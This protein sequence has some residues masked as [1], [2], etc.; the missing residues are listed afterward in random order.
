MQ[1]QC[2]SEIVE[3]E[4]LYVD[5]LSLRTNRHAKCTTTE[6]GSSRFEVRG[7]RFEWV[8]RWFICLFQN[9]GNV[10]Y[11]KKDVKV[12]QM[13]ESGKVEKWNGGKVERWKGV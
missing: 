2:A 1:P 8:W 3:K 7:S 6:V 5:S 10:E 13:S 12:R 4:G 9:V 11:G